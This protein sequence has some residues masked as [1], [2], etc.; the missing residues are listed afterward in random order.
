MNKKVS[1]IMI[2]NN[3]VYLKE[4]LLSISRQSYK[5]WECFIILNINKKDMY[6]I[7]KIV[8]PLKA[9]YFNKVCF[10]SYNDILIFFRQY[11]KDF[12]I[13]LNSYDICDTERLKKQVS[14]MDKNLNCNLCSCLSKSLIKKQLVND[15]FLLNNKFSSRNDIDTALLAGYYPLCLYTMLIR[16][17]FLTN[18]VKVLELSENSI[19][20]E[21]DL[22]LFMLKY[23]QVEKVNDILYY[24]KIQPNS[25]Y[26]CNINKYQNILRSK[27]KDYNKNQ[28]ILYRPYFNKMLQDNIKKMP[29]N[30]T[31]YN[32]LMIIDELN[33]GGTET[34]ILNLI[35]SLSMNGFY[36]IIATSG[37]ILIDLFKLNNIKIVPFSIEYDK[38]TNNISDHTYNKLLQ[39]INDNNINLLHCHFPKEMELCKNFYDLYGFP[40]VITLHGT[41]Y[42]NLAIEYSCPDA[43]LVIAVSYKVAD[44]YSKLLTKIQPC[45]VQVLYNSIDTDYINLQPFSLRDILKIPQGSR[46]I[47]YCSRL[48]WSKGA[49]AEIF[50]KSFEELA[51]K[52]DDIYAVI[53][54][55]GKKRLMI[56]QF[57]NNINNK[58]KKK[59][60]FIL[61]ATYNVKDY[62]K[63]SLFVVGTGR[64]ALEALSCSKSVLALGS[65]G[66]LGIVNEDNAE[67]MIEQYFGDHGYDNPELLST[68]TKDMDVLLSN[69]EMLKEINIW[70]R[71]WVIENFDE[72]KLSSKIGKLYIQIIS[73]YKDKRLY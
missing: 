10:N 8:P 34:Y 31:I 12:F 50:L 48:S 28:F 39:I 49:V 17:I 18:I 63:D 61:G 71:K 23:T 45:N 3:T 41:F 46:I 52:Y 73:N 16:K 47:I 33:L 65:K 14:F 9:S 59:R 57:S 62:F 67:K 64:V 11:I 1:I 4:S 53:L 68:L 54:G 60:I 21:I 29:I 19:M 43:S 32:I 42:S 7:I 27:L 15:P 37:G 36:I 13:I 66:Y 6:H 26:K 20:N 2:V 72:K 30:K 35:K 24:H 44:T 38:I 70:S 25:L 5:N 51:Y 56:E 40:Y 55:E 22:V 69:N 58:L